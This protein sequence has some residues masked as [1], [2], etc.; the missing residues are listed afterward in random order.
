MIRFLAIN[1]HRK[2]YR[3]RGQY[4]ASPPR[5]RAR[6]DEGV[7]G[8]PICLD[9]EKDA[10]QN[11]CAT[12]ADSSSIARLSKSPSLELVHPRQQFQPS[13][14]FRR[15]SFP[16]DC[17]REQRQQVP[18]CQCLKH[19]HLPLPPPHSGQAFDAARRSP[20]GAAN[21]TAEKLIQATSG[22]LAEVLNVAQ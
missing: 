16:L 12:P 2:A 1:A 8:T 20:Y 11:A 5:G 19:E 3:T 18:R 21:N 17:H 10:F 22:A 14:I 7:R 13:L 4:S 15:G 9:I 6:I